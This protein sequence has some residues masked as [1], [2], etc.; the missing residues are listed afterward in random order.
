MIQQ[1]AI[2]TQDQ[3]EYRKS[4]DEIT[5]KFSKTEEQ[6]KRVDT[7]LCN[8]LEHRGIIKNFIKS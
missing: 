2:T 4:H 7:K 5:Q 8:L 3:N 6:K 1:N